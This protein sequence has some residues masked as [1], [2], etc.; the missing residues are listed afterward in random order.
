M[1]KFLKEAC[2]RISI[3][4]FFVVGFFFCAVSWLNFLFSALLHRWMG[5]KINWLVSQNVYGYTIH[6][7]LEYLSGKDLHW[8][9]AIVGGLAL[10][11]AILAFFKAGKIAKK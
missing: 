2:R 1:S 8:A 7:Y 6:D 9:F 10:L 4:I 11:C 5:L 3:F